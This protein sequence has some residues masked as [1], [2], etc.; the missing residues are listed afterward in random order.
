MV[1]YVLLA[2]VGVLIVVGAGILVLVSLSAGDTGPRR[3]ALSEP[4][5]AVFFDES[6]FSVTAS[7]EVA[8]DPA[9]V[10][11]QVADGPTVSLGP[12]FRGPEVR[13]DQRTFRGLVSANSRVVEMS[14][15][16]GLV[17]VGTG[18]SI[19]FVVG[20]FAERVAVSA[21]SGLGSRIEYTFALEPR[22]FRF[23]PLR[24]AAVFVRPVMSAAI[25]RAF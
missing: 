21:G 25:K 7:V 14:A 24:W 23:I 10:W 13:G 20:A 3:F 22:M 5:V 19:P 15:Q 17:A 18:I 6:A 9:A 16:G 8:A 4:D 12:I 2:V 1:T 11:S